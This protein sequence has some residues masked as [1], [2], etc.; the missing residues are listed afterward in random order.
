M[1]EMQEAEKYMYVYFVVQHGTINTLIYVF[2]PTVYT[3]TFEPVCSFFHVYKQN[4]TCA[5][6]STY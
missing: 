1:L 2:I 5:F 6:N 3:C 4:L